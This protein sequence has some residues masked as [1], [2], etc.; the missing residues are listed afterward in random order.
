[1]LLGHIHFDSGSAKSNLSELLALSERADSVFRNKYVKMNSDNSRVFLGRIVE[2]PFFIPEEVGRDS[3]F[4]QTAILRGEKFK[5]LPSYY[6]LARVEILGEYDAKA[7]TTYGTSSRPLPKATVNDLDPAEVQ[8]LIGLSGDMLLGQLAGYTDV[9]VR[10]DSGSKKVLPR[11]VG[12]F[13]TVGA[14]KTN[15]AQVLIEEASKAGYAIVVLDVEGEYVEMDEPSTE[16][17]LYE[18]LASF[19]LEPRGIDKKKFVVFHPSGSEPARKDSTEFDVRFSDLSPYLISELADLTEPQEGLFLKIVEELRER[20]GR[21][22][23]TRKP[24]PGRVAESKVSAIA[25][26]EGEEGLTRG[27]EYTIADALREIPEHE[28]VA[29]GTRWP[30]ERKLRSLQRTGIFDKGKDNLE[31][32]RLLQPGRVSVVDVSGVSHDGAKNI[33]IAW[34]L[35][36]VFN[37]KLR[38][39]ETC[40]TL[41]IIEEAH[42][43]VSKEA[44]GKMTATMDMLKLIA[45]RGRKRWLGLVFVSQQPSHLPEEIFE[46]CNMRFIHAIKSDHNLTPVRRTSGDVISELWDMV[47]GLGP[48]QALVTSSQF[49]HTIMVNV[50]PSS[51]KRRLTD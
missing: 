40:K 34:V 46:L 32:K 50:R 19:R 21:P 14:G 47:P 31:V 6:T 5:A 43:F 10:V 35:R 1:M 39:P 41:V 16:K 17:G 42:T 7:G 20:A 36:E 24:A 37:E 44:R 29:G 18:R 38:N 28:E 4:A 30:L 11:N 26:L 45:R 33:A 2:G 22:G 23:R 49:S 51:T 3:A 12:I 25:F 27:G 15:T 48:G 13:G 8:R 9:Q